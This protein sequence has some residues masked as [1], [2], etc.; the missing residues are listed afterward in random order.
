MTNFAAVQRF[1][2]TCGTGIPAWMAELFDGLDDSAEVRQ[3]VAASVA[4]EQCLTL[5]EQGVTEFHFYTLNRAELTLAICHRLGL[6]GGAAGTPTPS[7]AT[8]G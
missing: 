7:M 3:L 1:A 6:K 5:R 8:G 4:V 2:A